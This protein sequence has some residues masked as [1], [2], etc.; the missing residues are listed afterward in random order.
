[1]VPGK[2][3]AVTYM[4]T[5]TRLLSVVAQHSLMGATHMSLVSKS[6]MMTIDQ[7]S[8]SNIGLSTSA[9][10]DPTDAAIIAAA[11]TGTGSGQSGAT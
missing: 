1:M 3:Y 11:G 2:T 4:G 9:L 7:T 10:G 6:G 8:V 5:D